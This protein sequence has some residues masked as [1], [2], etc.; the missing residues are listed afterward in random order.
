MP[1]AADYLLLV[2]LATCGILQLAS[3]FNRSTPLLFIPNTRLNLL[4][5]LLLLA[6]PFVW[7][8][9]SE[10][11]NLPDTAGGLNGNQQAA[12]FLIGSI[13]AVLFTFFAT[14]LRGPKLGPHPQHSPSGLD[15]LRHLTYLRAL[16]LTLRRLKRHENH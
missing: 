5:A 12:L 13:A 1:F 7:F 15:A 4:L 16:S 2:F 11:R 6:G 3:V 10:P 8:F 14:S 9:A